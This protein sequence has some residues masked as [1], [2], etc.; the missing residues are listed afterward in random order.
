MLNFG[1]LYI[2]Y[3][4]VESTRATGRKYS[5]QGN[6]PDRG[7][8]APRSGSFTLLRTQE[9]NKIKMRKKRSKIGMF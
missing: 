3:L 1:V 9:F 2:T 5:H 7:K 8:S 6:D 4:T